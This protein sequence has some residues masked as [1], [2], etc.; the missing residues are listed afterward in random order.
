MRNDNKLFKLGKKLMKQDYKRCMAHVRKLYKEE[1]VE[2][3]KTE[4]IKKSE[5]HQQAC[6]VRFPSL[7]KAEWF[8]KCASCVIENQGSLKWA[9]LKR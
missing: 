9:W 8:G 5:E 3:H 2:R 6:E 4:L 1:D 7:V